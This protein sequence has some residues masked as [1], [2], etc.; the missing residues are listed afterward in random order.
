MQHV[1]NGEGQGA[2]HDPAEHRVVKRHHLHKRRHKRHRNPQ[3]IKSVYDALDDAN[4]DA[5]AV[6]QLARIDPRINQ[7]EDYQH[8]RDRI[9]S[10]EHGD[11]AFDDGRKAEICN[12]KADHAPSDRPC[13]VFDLAFRKLLEVFASRAYKTQRRGDAG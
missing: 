7:R 6:N 11:G 9:N 1:G 2:R 4:I 5:G 10:D 8:D 3:N 12:S 13:F